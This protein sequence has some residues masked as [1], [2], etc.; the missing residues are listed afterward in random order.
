MLSVSKKTQFW[1]TC[2]LSALHLL[3]TVLSSSSSP[4]YLA[5]ILHYRPTLS[6]LPLH[7]F[8][9][10]SP[11]LLLS[12]SHFL[13]FTV[14]T[15]CRLLTFRLVFLSLHLSSLFLP[16]PIPP[17]VFLQLL[18]WI[19]SYAIHALWSNQSVH[20]HFLLIKTWRPPFPLLI[21]LHS[22]RLPQ[23]LSVE[24]SSHLDSEFSAVFLF[25]PSL[26]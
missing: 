25:L 2:H 14:L 22:F 16:S 1:V 10:L 20:S 17:P 11:P 9:S 18:T 12:P 21:C 4:L 24:P 23:S 13:L 15:V 26:I 3:S 5:F 6:C 7:F 19:G 8:I